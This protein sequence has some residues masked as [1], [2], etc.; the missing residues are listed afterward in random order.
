MP[1]IRKQKYR[2]RKSREADM[3]S[4]IEILDIMLGSSHLEREESELSNSVRVPES[5]RFSALTNHDL[6]SHSNS[7]G[8]E[9]RGYAG[10]GQNSRE[11]DSSSEINRLSGELNQRITQELN[12]MNSVSSQIQRAI[13][14]AINDQVLPQIQA[15][16]ESGQGQM[17]NKG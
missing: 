5:P 12:D 2:A 14:E 1:T 3:L 6:N 16:L 8:N 4:D 10:N 17:S 9:I 7:R 13:S 15:T 11:T